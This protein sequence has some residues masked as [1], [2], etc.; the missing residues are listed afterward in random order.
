MTTKTVSENDE[1]IAGKSYVV[2]CNV[3][4]AAYQGPL[5]LRAAIDA[6]IQ[7]FNDSNKRVERYVFDAASRKLT[8]QVKAVAPPERNPAIGAIL[9]WGAAG[10]VLVA[11]IYGIWLTVKEIHEI[12]EEGS[13]EIGPFKFNTL[14]LVVA[15][16][17]ALFVFQGFRRGG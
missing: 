8:V 14:A 3:N 5:T 12:I 16:A 4:V 2:V 13:T 7:R 6:A 1:W 15:G 17:G 9:L 11:A 10:I